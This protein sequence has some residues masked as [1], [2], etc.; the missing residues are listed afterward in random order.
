MLAIPL[1]SPAL[2][3]HAAG[4]RGQNA[5]PA[6]W[7]DLRRQTSFAVA[8]DAHPLAVMGDGLT[9]LRFG[10]TLGTLAARD[11]REDIVTMGADSTSSDAI[12]RD[13]APAT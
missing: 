7:A 13:R 6:Y 9:A 1:R 5:C 3:G 11:S 2:H 10:S 12:R 8:S 4:R